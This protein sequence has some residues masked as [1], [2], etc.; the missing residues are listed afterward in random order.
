MARI[1]TFGALSALGTM[2]RNWHTAWL[3]L[4]AGTGSGSLAAF[5]FGNSTKP[6]PFR[7]LSRRPVFLVVCD[8]QSLLNDPSLHILLKRIPLPRLRNLLSLY[9]KFLLLSRTLLLL[10]YFTRVFHYTKTIE[11]GICGLPRIYLLYS[12]RYLGQHRKN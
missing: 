11:V 3:S 12:T 1:L 10:F 5:H 4:G 9:I 8:L 2:Q 6:K 7:S